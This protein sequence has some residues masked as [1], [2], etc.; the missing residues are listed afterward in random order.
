MNQSKGLFD[1]LYTLTYYTS[2]LPLKL[3]DILH[4]TRFSGID[5][6]V[7]KNGRYAYFP[8]PMY[9]FPSLER[10]IR[11]N[12]DGG[13]GHCVL[14]IGCGKGF[15]LSFF[16]RMCF[17]RVS[18]IEYDARMC[19]LAR[20][21]LSNSH[22]RIRIY[23]GDAAS[24][25]G[26]QDYDVFYLYNPFDEKVLERCINRIMLSLEDHPRNLT[27]FYCNPRYGGLLEKK[28]FLKEKHFYYKTAV[29][30]LKQL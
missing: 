14:D 21:N 26:Y 16:A 28:G 18:G 15:A 17:D 24:F 29:F 20:R 12:L 5:F 6:S 4:G 22:R 19:A 23:K 2:L 9:S 25:R 11:T 27:V 10:Y 7:E 3:Y 1:R 30:H 8:S 13:K